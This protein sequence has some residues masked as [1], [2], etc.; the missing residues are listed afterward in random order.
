MDSIDEII[1]EIVNSS[2]PSILATVIHVEGSAY[3]K[4][5]TAMLFL[6]DG[7]QFGVISAGCLEN[8]LAIHAEKFLTKDSFKSTIIIYDMSAEDDL[9]WGRGAG[10]NGKVHI[11]LEKV[12][13]KMR[14]Q[15]RILRQYLIQN[16]PVKF[17][18][19]LHNETVKQTTFL[20]NDGQYFG[21]KIQGLP[22]KINDKNK[23]SFTYIDEIKAEAFIQYFQPRPRLF[24]FGAGID[25]RP[26]A[27]IAVK[28]GFSVTVWDWRPNNCQP[29]YFPN[30][31]ILQ[32]K[33][34]NQL[35]D[36]LHFTDQD[37]AII[38]THDFQ[39]DKEI[40]HLLLKKRPLN[41]LGILGPRKRTMRLLNGDS[42]PD[43]LHSPVGLAIGAEG[44]HEIAISIIADLIKTLRLS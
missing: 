24:V 2:V 23:S 28:I 32:N 16:M 3:R 9:S 39:K 27:T 8:D 11:L 20:T 5:G 19:I 22:S 44:P 18:R 30:A 36:T 35:I 14:Y 21:D 17:I 7:Q 37:S 1:E 29:T 13:P 31:T 10:C 43:V 40:L 25:V 41:Y 15:F 38:M 34:V 33:S 42:I 6:E 12:T 4:E 26:L